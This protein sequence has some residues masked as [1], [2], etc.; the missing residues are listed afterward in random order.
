[1]VVKVENSTVSYKIR[2]SQRLPNNDNII[3]RNLKVKHS[4]QF[5][6]KSETQIEP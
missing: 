5:E 4:R 3:L 2:P 6:C 1:M